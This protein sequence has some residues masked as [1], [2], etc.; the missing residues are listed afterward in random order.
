MND[1]DL[2][3]VADNSFGPLQAADDHVIQ[4]DGNTLLGQRKK[5]Q[6][7][8]EVDLSRNFAGLTIYR[9]GYH[10]SILMRAKQMV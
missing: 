7:A 5:L 3:A 10:G 4:L 6:K 8:I 1:L 9:Y 2:V